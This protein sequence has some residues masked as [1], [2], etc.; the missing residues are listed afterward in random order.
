M[1]LSRLVRSAEVLGVNASLRLAYARLAR[2]GSVTVPIH[3]RR[4]HVRAGSSDVSVVLSVLVE[5]D[6]TA[7]IQNHCRHLDIRHVIDAG[8]NIGMTTRVLARTFPDIKLTAI[9]PD[10]GNCALL[11][12]NTHDLS[13]VQVLQAGLWSDA[14]RLTVANPDAPSWSY[15]L[16]ASPDEDGGLPAVTL[17]DLTDR[18][19]AGSVFLKMDVE[20]AEK[21]VLESL[22]GRASE[23]IG[24]VLVETH[25]RKEP[26]S[27][28]ALAEYLARRRMHVTVLGES[29]LGYCPP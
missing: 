9:E 19:E 3:G 1:K 14:V 6:Y 11:R 21:Q 25:D 12:E 18:D 29:I 23:R 5:T 20:G 2:S 24:A 13:S 15:Q 27:G 4:C 8:A 16:Q 7:K 17:A 28:T 26:G 10:A 22:A